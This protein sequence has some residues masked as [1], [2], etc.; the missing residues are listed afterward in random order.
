M[1]GFRGFKGFRDFGVERFEG[2]G[3]FVTLWVYG[4]LGIRIGFLGFGDSSLFAICRV[5]RYTEA[6]GFMDLLRRG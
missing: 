2:L 4:F 5:T 1:A 3:V 6:S